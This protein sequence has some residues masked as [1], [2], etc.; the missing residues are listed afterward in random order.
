[1]GVGR[2]GNPHG[3][4]EPAMQLAA[5]AIRLAGESSGGRTTGPNQDP[6]NLRP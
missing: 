3:A 1:M 6:E 4:F 2:T 5:A